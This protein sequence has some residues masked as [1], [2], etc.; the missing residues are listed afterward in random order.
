MK[1]FLSQTVLLGCVLLCGLAS[2]TTWAASVVLREHAEHFGSV[3][4][5]GDIADVSSATTA[6]VDDL[7]T[8][9]LLA[10]PAAGTNLF[11]RLSQ[12][13]DLLTSRGVD[14]NDVS[15]SGAAVVEIGEA[16]QPVV[17]AKKTLVEELPLDEVE[18]IVLHAIEQY[19]DQQA[20]RTGWRIEFELDE[21]ILS[22]IA[23][24][25]RQFQVRGGRRPWSGTQ[26]F[27]LST[28][29]SAR[30][31]F[32]TAQVV[33]VGPA[34][35][36]LRKIERGDLIRATDVEVRQHEGRLPATALTS[37]GQ[38]IGKESLRAIP[39]STII[40]KNFV[41]EPLMVERGETVTVFARTGGVSVR[42]FATAKQDGAQGELIQV[43]TLDKKERF[44]ARI[45]ARRELEVFATGARARDF[46]SFG[47]RD[48]R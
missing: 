21:T 8:T 1:I 48:R 37:L 30:P 4:R 36:V 33:Q 16:T 35:F 5:L 20:G 34:V 13:R 12:I 38:V 17:E 25:G 29:D 43:E 42:T 22:K 14:L 2:S 23:Q 40:Q 47:D 9:P 32:V 26:R 6:E 15:F 39:L 27:K 19:L 10:A 41:R 18:S 24:L 31:I 7:A 46:A 45:S 3:V 11:L 28:A 44:S